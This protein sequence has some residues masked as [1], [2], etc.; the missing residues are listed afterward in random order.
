MS[1]IRYGLLCWGRTNK[2]KM[3][4]VNDRAIRCIHF[5]G[6][7]EFVSKFKMTK[8]KMLKICS[9]MSWVVLFINTKII[10]TS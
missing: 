1:H 5:K 6:Y 8:K 4:E 10:F 7:N 3:K 2:I 9:S